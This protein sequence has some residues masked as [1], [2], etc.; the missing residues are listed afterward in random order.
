MDAPIVQDVSINAFFI[1]LKT[2]D[3]FCS[4][5]ASSLK[6]NIVENLK[7]DNIKNKKTIETIPPQL[8]GSAK[9]IL[10]IYNH[11]FVFVFRF[12]DL[13]PNRIKKILLLPLQYKLL[14]YKSN[15]LYL[16]LN[17][18]AAIITGSEMHLKK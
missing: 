13:F 12:F 9:S 3:V 17:K 1:C 11:Y 4:I 15:I 10:N 8:T 14:I 7:N 2:L 18:I 6:L 16:V 5:K